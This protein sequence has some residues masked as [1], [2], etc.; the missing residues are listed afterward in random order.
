M[1]MKRLREVDEKEKKYVVGGG[2][3]GGPADTAVSVT[4]MLLRYGLWT[5]LLI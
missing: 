5:M 3:V 2:E 4:T 1:Q